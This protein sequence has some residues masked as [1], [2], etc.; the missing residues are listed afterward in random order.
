MPIRRPTQPRDSFP[1]RKNR[2]ELK[3]AFIA[4][5]ARLAPGALAELAECLPVP[6]GDVQR[7]R[8]KD[9][10][11]RIGRGPKVFDWPAYDDWAARHG[12]LINEPAQDWIRVW[13]ASLGAQPLTGAGAPALVQR[14]TKAYN[15][16]WRAE[17][18]SLEG[19][20]VKTQ[21]RDRRI[22][23]QTVRLAEATVRWQ[24]LRQ[25][26]SAILASMQLPVDRL[27]DLRF[28]VRETAEIL[29][30]RRRVG[31]RGRPPVPKI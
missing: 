11:L 5:L 19:R 9:G 30:L 13:A 25:P 29:S 7:A 17:K 2:Q 23:R 12:L 27:A 4:A 31:R 26:W 14:M 18:R 24:V 21:V 10:Q 16:A 20:G 28:G 22:G 6:R 1:F 3:A 8:R 15:S